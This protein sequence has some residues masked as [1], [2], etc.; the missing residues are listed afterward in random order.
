[1]SGYWKEKAMTGR[2]RTSSRVRFN[3]SVFA[4]APGHA[5]AEIV[6]LLEAE[7]I[8]LLIDTRPEVLDHELL[9]AA[10][11][12]AQTYF[13]ARPQLAALA[14]RPDA[15]PDAA[16]AWAAHMALRHRACL[17]GDARVADGVARLVGLRVIALDGSA[18]PTAPKP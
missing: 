8:E 9:A 11:R 15:E 1:M 18:A 4:L 13:A 5:L 7:D 6:S 14:E 2:P 10:C 3:R 12:E 17:L 16:H